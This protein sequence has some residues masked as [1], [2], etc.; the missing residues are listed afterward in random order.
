MIREILCD[1]LKHLYLR[2]LHSYL[3]VNLYSYNVTSKLKNPFA[4]KLYNT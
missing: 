4:I 3:H 2:T 1:V